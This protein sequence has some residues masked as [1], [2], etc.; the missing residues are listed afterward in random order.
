[1]PAYLCSRYVLGIA[2][3]IALGMASSG[4]SRGVDGVIHD[5][6]S[7]ASGSDKENADIVSLSL[8]SE[9]FKNQPIVGSIRTIQPDSCR[10]YDSTATNIDYG[11]RKIV[12]VSYNRVFADQQSLS[13]CNFIQTLGGNSFTFQVNESGDFSVIVKL[14]PQSADDLKGTSLA[15]DPVMRSGVDATFKLNV[16]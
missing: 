9:I 5:T 8:P 14:H 11:A 10:E 13:I 6:A 15:F 2:L 1:M 16:K 3:F 7:Q 12:V 4:C